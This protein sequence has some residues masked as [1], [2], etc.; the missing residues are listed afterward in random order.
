MPS[1]AICSMALGTATA[2]FFGWCGAGFDA[3]VAVDSVSPLHRDD[4]G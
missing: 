1:P 2:I 3:A 4:S